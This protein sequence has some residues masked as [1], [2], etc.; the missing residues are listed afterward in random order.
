VL[1]G[2]EAP[3]RDEGQALQV[4]GAGVVARRHLD[5]V[6]R[7]PPRQDRH[8]VHV[9]GRLDEFYVGVERARLVGFD[10]EAGDAVRDRGDGPVLGEREVEVADLV[11]QE[12][13]E[14]DVVARRQPPP[15][16]EFEFR[17]AAAVESPPRPGFREFLPELLEPSPVD[18][19]GHVEK[20]EPRGGADSE[21]EDE[22][23]EGGVRHSVRRRSPL[24]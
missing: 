7:V 14:R 11:A 10:R 24:V 6:V 1:A 19:G 2:G 5:E 12:T 17:V 3:E 22:A 15:A 16:E 4:D 13:D 9:R 20:V 18:E 8:P 21:V 23:G